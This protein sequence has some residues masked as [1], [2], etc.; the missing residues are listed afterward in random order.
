[1][2]YYVIHMGR[3]DEESASASPS[4]IEAVIRLDE[5]QRE[6]WTPATILRDDRAICEEELRDDALHERWL[7]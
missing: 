7:D 2:P 1:M 3:G 4:S 6:G 5:A